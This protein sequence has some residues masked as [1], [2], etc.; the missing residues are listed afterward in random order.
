MDWALGRRNTD[1]VYYVQIN[2]DIS[3]VDFGWSYLYKRED[4]RLLFQMEKLWW[5]SLH[6][7]NIHSWIRGRLCHPSKPHSAKALLPN[8]TETLGFFMWLCPCQQHTSV[9]TSF[10]SYS[11]F[12]CRDRL[13]MMIR[14]CDDQEARLVSASLA[15]LVESALV[16]GGC[17][18]QHDSSLSL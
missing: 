3:L 4:F 13:N 7:I 9:R 6:T 16:V 2:K 17:Y 10:T 1:M 11:C 15:M 12:S 8:G 14:S 18:Y 5:N